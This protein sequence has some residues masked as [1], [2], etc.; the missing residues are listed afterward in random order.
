MRKLSSFVNLTAKMPAI[1]G[2]D[3][4][5]A[6]ALSQIQIFCDSVNRYL[7]ALGISDAQLAIVVD[8]TGT[9]NISGQSVRLTGKLY[10]SGDVTRLVD[11]LGTPAT[12][13]A[14]GEKGD[15][16][17]DGSYAYFCVDLNTWLRVAIATW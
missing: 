14:T 17:V 7:L 4:D 16:K 1:R 13:A 11:T 6:D 10:A 2:R 15:F 3:R 5:V 9:V 12:A 8:P